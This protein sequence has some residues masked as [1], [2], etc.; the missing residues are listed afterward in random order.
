MEKSMIRQE[1]CD[2]NESKTEN[3]KYVR[4]DEWIIFF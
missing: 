3:L 4:F 2:N 1:H